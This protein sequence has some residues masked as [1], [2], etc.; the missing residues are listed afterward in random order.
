MP[1][2]SGQDPGAVT[3]QLVQGEGRGGGVCDDHDVCQHPVILPKTEFKSSVLGNKAAGSSAWIMSVTCKYASGTRI[4]LERPS[5]TA[6]NS[7]R[8]FKISSQPDS[9]A[10]RDGW[11]SS[12]TGLLVLLGHWGPR[13]MEGSPLWGHALPCNRDLIA[14]STSWEHYRKQHKGTTIFATFL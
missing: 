8:C 7:H 4:I 10:Q 11:D 3:E 2:D 14:A 1:V 6:F 12:C 9:R 5:T 13:C